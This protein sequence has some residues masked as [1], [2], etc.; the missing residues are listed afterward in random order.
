MRTT[1]RMVQNATDLVQLLRVL[2][3]QLP[4]RLGVARSSSQGAAV[5]ARVH[6]VARGRNKPG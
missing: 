2:P 4:L 3:L 1:E 6:T 5:P